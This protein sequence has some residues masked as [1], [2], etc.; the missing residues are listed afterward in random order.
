[1]H[2][3]SLEGL[4]AK[5]RADGRLFLN[6]TLVPKNPRPEVSSVAVP[7]TRLAEQA[8][9]IMGAAM[10]MLGAFVASTQLVGA[11]SMVSAMR[12][13]LPPHRARMADA[14]AALLQL[15]SDFVREASASAS[16]FTSDA[17][18]P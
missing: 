4:A 6:A 12:A 5:V 9:N 2:P 3:A 1:M 15:G 14:N 11:D 10:V 18:R 16:R 8:G 17:S 7:A 13:S